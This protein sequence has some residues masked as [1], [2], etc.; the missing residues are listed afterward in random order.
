MWLIA[1][2][3]A[4]G[5]EKLIV[6]I[7]NRCQRIQLSSNTLYGDNLGFYPGSGL[8]T[9][10]FGLGCKRDLFSSSNRMFNYECNLWPPIGLFIPLYPVDA[11]FC[12]TPPFG[13]RG[14]LSSW[15]SNMGKFSVFTGTPS[16]YYPICFSILLF[17]FM[18]SYFLLIFSKSP[19]L[20]VGK[21]YF[22][23]GWYMTCHMH[24]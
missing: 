19:C 2:P 7:S 18:S 17:S 22:C 24:A 21:R 1:S 5:I 11:V 4:P 16:Q 13:I 23:R 10:C 15:K 6:P 3:C 9:E 8:P 14:I 20:Y 12:L